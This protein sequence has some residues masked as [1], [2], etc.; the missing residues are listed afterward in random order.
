MIP[1]QSVH[2]FHRI[3]IEE[4]ARELDAAAGVIEKIRASGIEPS[5]IP[6][7]HYGEIFNRPRQNFTVQ[8][9]QSALILAVEKDRFLYRGSERINSWNRSELY[10]N[11]LVRNCVYNCDYCFLQGMH[12]SAHTLMYLNNSDF[13]RAAEAQLSNGPM[14][15]S[16]SYLS[17]ILA[18][19]PLY[20]Y[21]AEWIRFASGRENFAL[22]IRTKSDYYQAISRLQPADNV[23]LVWSLSPEEISRHHERGTAS[24]RNRLF[25]ASRAAA[26]GWSLKITFDPVLYVEGWREYYPR[27]IREI[28]SRIPAEQV[29]EVSFGV[30]RMNPDYL[31]KIRALRPDTPHLHREYHSDRKEGLSSYS[32]AIISEIR[33]VMEDEISRYLPDDRVFFVHG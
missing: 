2:Q 28:F 15:M 23:Y 13:M 32:P 20:P 12:S 4:A 18:F 8:K 14:Y 11:A 24:F 29:S 7:E 22:E 10:Y 17:E 21:S 5:I 19:E 33:A 3:Y 25:A 9:H 16:I 30:F 27:M 6:I 1:L 26:D 31:K